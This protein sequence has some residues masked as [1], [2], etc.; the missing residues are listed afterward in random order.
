MALDESIN[1]VFGT[2]GDERVKQSSSK[3]VASLNR[4]G[5]GYRKMREQVERSSRIFGLIGGRAAGAGYLAG[6]VGYQM[7]DQGER[8][9]VSQAAQLATFEAVF[10][11]TQVATQAVVKSATSGAI[12][13]ALPAVGAV[14]GTFLGGPLGTIIGDVV[15]VVVASVVA[16]AVADAVDSMM[17][18]NENP[19][20]G[21]TSEVMYAT[22]RYKALMEV[23]MNRYYEL[24]DKAKAEADWFA[25]FGEY[26]IDNF[27]E[28]M[29][30]TLSAIQEIWTGIEAARAAQDT[31]L[32][33]ASGIET[34]EARR[35]RLR[36]ER[37]PDFR[38][39]RRLEYGTNPD[40]IFELPRRREVEN[41]DLFLQTLD[42][43]NAMILERLNL[44]E[45]NQRNV[46]ERAEFRNRR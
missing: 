41:P 32:L 37:L 46:L 39:R 25:V 27:T 7:G 42:K 40:N 18:G 10:A 38:F 4:V 5:E 30:E 28:S 19:L 33:A 3:V 34:P 44:L 13:A 6:M 1:I 20:R 29:R 16:D 8:G 36:R 45:E 21:V 2:I 23:F 11:S 24:E 15:G 17:Q 14:I 26:E 31:A 43:N 12:K 35:E 9:I 22:N